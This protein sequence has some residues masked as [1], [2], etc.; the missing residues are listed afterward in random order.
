MIHPLPAVPRLLAASVTGISLN[1]TQSVDPWWP[2]IWVAPIPLLV[3]VLSTSSLRET[4]RLAIVASVLGLASTIWY[5]LHLDGLALEIAA[6]TILF[7]VPHGVPLVATVVLWRI[8][9]QD[10]RWYATLLFALVAAAVDL[11]FTSISSH[12]TWASWANSQMDA[13]PVIQTAALGGTPAVVFLITLPPAAAALAVARGRMIERPLLAYGLPLLLVVS[14]I[15]YGVAR[16]A[17]TPIM[18]RVPIGLA[19]ADS[20]DFLVSDPGGPDDATLATYL[21]AA[22]TLAAT[23]AEIV[24]LPEKIEVVAETALPRLQARLSSWAREHRTHLVVGFAM[25]APDHRDNRAWLFD[26]N[27]DRIVDYAK[28]HLVP[29]GEF[30]FRPG[31]RDA[32]I[33]IDGH[34]VGVTICKDMDFPRLARGYG[35]AAVQTV[36]T[37]AWNLGVDGVYHSRMAALRGVEQGFSVIRAARQGV[38]MVSD[39]Y[40]RI[41]A[42]AY[43]ADAP[44]T[45]L[46]ADAPLGGFGTLYG[47]TGDAFG[48]GCVIVVG[49]LALRSMRRAVPNGDCVDRSRQL[50]PHEDR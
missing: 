35:R 40:G 12:G 3:A 16:L 31:D 44:V 1:L 4:A 20:T 19:A 46:L 5:C 2:A 8:V 36:L 37:P 43:T 10:A 14:A 21:E 29:I 23:G 41:I 33:A 6:N 30:R 34:T 45:T 22:T 25:V 49:L 50:E 26:K 32:V 48:W 11:A 9:A 47:K 24:I 38:L 28:R 7:A 13:L 27:G 39:P 17:H 15:G 18:A 42:E